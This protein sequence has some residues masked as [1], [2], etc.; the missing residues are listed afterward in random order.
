MTFQK[1]LS[2]TVIL[3]PM[4]L[5]MHNK[6]AAFGHV[7]RDYDWPGR[8][9]LSFSLQ[10]AIQIMLTT[11]SMPFL[12]P[13][14]YFMLHWPSFSLFQYAPCALCIPLRPPELDSSPFATAWCWMMVLLTANLNGGGASLTLVSDMRDSRIFFC[15]GSSEVKRDNREGGRYGE[16]TMICVF[17]VLAELWR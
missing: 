7:G 15:E 10:T 12:S 3:T 2:P 14:S 6:D 13:P 17:Q 9:F 16:H 8:L 1:L 4:L 5:A 11:T